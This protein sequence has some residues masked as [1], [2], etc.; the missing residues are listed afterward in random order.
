MAK[1]ISSSYTLSDA[2][3]RT[4]LTKIQTNLADFCL[5]SAGLT[6]GSVSAAKVKIANTVYA[7]IDSVLVKKTTAEITL[8]T[9]NN[10]ANGKF[11]VIVLT[12]DAEGTVTPTN[13]TAGD[14]L[15]AVVFPAVPDDEV[16]IGFVI[17]NP[18]G[19]GNF[20]GG[21]TELTDA[22]VVPNAVYVNSISPF[23]VNIE[24]L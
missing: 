23:N 18:T 4:A 15:G 24:S 3:L 21:T 8:T 19:T 11:N 5:S 16:V 9:A 6:V 17:I 2:A 20:V 22:T 10:V 7:L 12:M 1:S 14:T 13:G